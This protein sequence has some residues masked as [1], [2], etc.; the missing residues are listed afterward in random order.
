MSNICRF[1]VPASRDVEAIID[2]IANNNSF[3]TAESL[4]AKINQNVKG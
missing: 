3:D 2:Y 1:T 4:L